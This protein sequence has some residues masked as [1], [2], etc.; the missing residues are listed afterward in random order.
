M[1]E[2]RGASLKRDDPREG[3]AFALHR[4]KRGLD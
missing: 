3:N 2:A 1:T 4:V